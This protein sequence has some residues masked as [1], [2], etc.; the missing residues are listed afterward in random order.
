MIDLNKY[1]TNI[2]VLFEHIELEDY[3]DTAIQS[4]NEYVLV[5]DELLGN[6]HM[7]FDGQLRQYATLGYRFVPIYLEDEKERVKAIIDYWKLLMVRDGEWT[8]ILRSVN[9]RV[10]QL[11][12]T[13]GLVDTIEYGGT[14]VSSEDKLTEY[15]RNI[16]REGSSSRNS[17][18][19]NAPINADINIINTPDNKGKVIDNNSG[20]EEYSG[21]DNVNTS[22]NVS[23][24]GSDKRTYDSPDK[25]K[26][27]LD[28]LKEYNVYTIVDNFIRTTIYES[29]RVM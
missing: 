25:Y 11:G 18:S 8:N 21:E 24:S 12:L 3:L 6:L 2:S 5:D 26:M 13:S 23:K 27:Y 4:L 7:I 29:N 19:E 15:G 28:I 16:S 9:G 20:V 10:E 22:R 14:E 17:M 1:L